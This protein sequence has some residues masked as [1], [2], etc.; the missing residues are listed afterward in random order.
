MRELWER[1]SAETT[2][3]DTL[4]GNE[5]TLDL[6]TERIALLAE[7]DAIVVG[8]VYANMSSEQVGFIFGLYVRPS[9]RR[10]GAVDNL[11]SR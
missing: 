8:V 11:L 1:L 10:R 6:I 4:A 9:S 7:G 2:Y 3:D 5:F